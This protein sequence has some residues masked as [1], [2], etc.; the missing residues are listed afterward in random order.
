VIE[1]PGFFRKTRF[2]EADVG[3]QGGSTCRIHFLK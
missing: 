2:L 1:K 3:E